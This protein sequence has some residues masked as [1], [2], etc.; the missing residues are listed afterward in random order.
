QMADSSVVK[1]PKIGLVL[2]GGGAKGLAHIGVLHVLEEVGI[3]PDFIA[4]TSMGSIIGGLYAA[5]YTADQ[6]SEMNRDLIWTDYL[7][8]AISLDKIS[9]EQKYDYGKY[10]TEFPI[11][12]RKL[13]LPSGIIES[14]TFWQFF[15]NMA[16]PVL[17]ISDFNQL[18]IPFRCCATEII[19]GDVKTFNSGSVPKAMRAS[20][21]IPGF[22]SPV[23]QND[24]LIFVDGGVG[25]N[26]PVEDMIEM[27]ADIIIGVYVGST[28]MMDPMQA[29]SVDKILMQTAFFAGLKESRHVMD[30]C[31]LLI[32]PDLKGKGS[33]DFEYGL[34]IEQFGRISAEK[35]KRQLQAIADSVYK[36]EPAIQIPRPKYDI[37][38]YVK[39]IKVEGAAIVSSDFIIAKSRIK[40]DTVVSKYDLNLALDNIFGTLYFDRV[41]YHFTP[42]D[43]GFTLVFDVQEKEPRLLKLALQINNFWGASVNL[44]Y[45]HNNLFSKESWFV[46]KAEISKI[47]RIK[48]SHMQFIGKRQRRSFE[49][50]TFFNADQI[51]VYIST[52]KAGELLEN[53]YGVSFLFNTSI[54]NNNQFSVGT[55]FGV[56]SLYPTDSY[57]FLVPESLIES[58]H[59]GG[60]KFWASYS[61]NS[62]DR[63]YFPRD[64]GSVDAK[65]GFGLKPFLEQTYENNEGILDSLTSPDN[66]VNISLGL[67]RYLTFRR[68]YTL[69]FGGDLRITTNRTPVFDSYYVGGSECFSRN[70]DVAFYGLGYRE[71]GIPNFIILKTQFRAK[72]YSELYGMARLNYFQGAEKELGIFDKAFDPEYDVFGYALGLGVNSIAGPIMVWLSGNTMDKNIWWYFSFGYNF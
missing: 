30:R 59:Y 48:A 70:N 40:L 21:A 46:A 49:L 17:G 50:N 10:I 24:T 47:P 63:H 42:L 18:P 72:I 67:E 43:D 52:N 15:H 68:R 4:G 25:R 6:I 61:K 37:T 38:Y 34:E 14:Q 71:V 44:N 1:R 57:K 28:E 33:Q 13:F 31:D 16:W 39:E 51:P 60:L 66:Y 29:R 3:V 62:L 32:V 69:M 45:S 53:D 27:G 11:R 26:F 64:G 54:N 5:G 9:M 8:N 23:I 2:S 35:H 41:A 55:T 7:S 22:F 12:G 19:K 56:V 58:A 20:M 65:V 36:N